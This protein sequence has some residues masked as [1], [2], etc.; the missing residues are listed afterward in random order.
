[1]NLKRILILSGLT[2]SLT[3]MYAQ[4]FT[5]ISS[6]E[7]SVWKEA[8]VKLQTKSNQTPVLKAETNE[9][10]QTFKKWGTCFNELGWDA[11]NM[12]SIDDQKV[13]LNNIF[14]PDG[15]LKFSMDVFR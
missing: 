14:A 11:L 15:E 8:E 6:T 10:I 3:G 9:S 12:L 5:W 13:V 2:I 4:S 7:G 1:M